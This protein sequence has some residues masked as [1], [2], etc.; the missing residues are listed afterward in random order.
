MLTFRRN[1]CPC[2]LAL[3]AAVERYVAPL[4]QGLSWSV[5]GKM[6]M[7]ES[8]LIENTVAQ[9]RL[10]VGKICIPHANN[11]SNTELSSCQVEQGVSL[12]L[13]TRCG[14]LS[15]VARCGQG[16]C[17]SCSGPA[18][19]VSTRAGH[20]TLAPRGAIHCPPRCQIRTARSGIVLSWHADNPSLLCSGLPRFFPTTGYVKSPSAQNAQVHLMTLS[21][22]YLVVAYNNSPSQRSPLNIALSR[23]QG[24]SWRMVGELETD[25]ALQFAYPTM[26]QVHAAPAT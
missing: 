17:F 14:T 22:G 10:Q 2:G 3:I 21:N 16:F 11:W 6:Q 7:E 23:D 24:R 5:T 9:V 26:D 18:L 1:S 8:W 12:A 15:S 4:L 20:Q 25:A 19:G 13:C